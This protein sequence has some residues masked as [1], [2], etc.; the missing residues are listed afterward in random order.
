M[1]FY[2]LSCWPDSQH[3]TG[4]DLTNGQFQESKLNEEKLPLQ[5][6]RVKEPPYLEM[7]QLGK[8]FW[9]CFKREQTLG[10]LFCKHSASKLLIWS[11]ILQEAKR[12]KEGKERKTKNNL[13]NN[14]LRHLKE[15]CFYIHICLFVY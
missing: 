1:Q 15:K 12:G 10:L 5:N 8:K 13:I 14:N 6:S 7:S 11:V 9:L 2:S 4:L 3:Q